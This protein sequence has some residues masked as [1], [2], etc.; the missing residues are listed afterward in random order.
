[1]PNQR[2]LI[3]TLSNMFSACISTPPF[4][5][6]VSFNPLEMKNLSLYNM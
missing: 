6:E 4:P 5:V 3:H 1:M 2:L